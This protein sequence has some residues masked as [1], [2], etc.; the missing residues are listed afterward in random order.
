[1][2]LSVPDHLH[3]FPGLPLLPVQD[4][5]VD[6]GGHP[7]HDDD[8]AERGLGRGHGAVEES[9][10]GGRRLSLLGQD[11]HLLD[12]AEHVVRELQEGAHLVGGAAA[13]A[14]GG[15]RGRGCGIGAR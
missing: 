3:L 5:A 2:V 15:G 4:R 14:G 7:D 11:D 8:V 13:A 9:P 10:G 6:G 12:E 1:M